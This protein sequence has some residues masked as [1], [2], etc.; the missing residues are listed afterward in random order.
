MQPQLAESNLSI[1]E[2]SGPG[3][4]TLNEYNSLFLRNRFALQASG[5]A[6]SNDIL[7]DELVQSTVWNKFSYSLG[8]YYYR[9]DG[10]REN[11]DQQRRLYNGY[12]QGMISP[13]T[14]WM[15]ELRY[16]K[17][18][19]GDLQI[20]FDPTEYYPNSRQSEERKSARIGLR[21][22]LKPN[23][24]I[25]GT[26][27]IG[28]NE[29]VGTGFDEGDFSVDI[30]GE[31]DSVMGEV[32]HI[33]NCG[34]FR[35]QSGAGYIY[36]DTND[37][38]TITFP[39]DSA[40]EEDFT[41]RH[42][43]LYSYAQVDLPHQ[44]TATLGLS[45]D[46]LDS[47]VK[48]REQLNPKIG[49]TWQP[50]NSTLIRGAVFSTVQRDLLYAQTVEPTHVSGFNQFFDDFDSTSAWTYG[51]GI[52]QNFSKKWFGGAQFYHRDLN[53]PFTEITNPE[54]PPMQSEDD[55]QEDIASVYL[56]WAPVSWTSI[57]LEY[58]YEK[59]T[60]DET[61]GQQEASDLTSH[62]LTPQV[63]FFLPA[64]FSARL[65]AH[66]IDQSGEFEI[67]PFGDTA[68]DGDQFW[69]VDLAIRYRLPKRYGILSL[70]VKKPV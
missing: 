20:L 70:G 58:Y 27:I 68:E 21:H 59:F 23:S 69:V 2:G 41:S 67:S 48:D 43:N 29:G 14:S 5:V 16:K 44:V 52:N 62:R 12:V 33:Y 60:Q 65:Q 17:D 4:A 54:L 53:V 28:N 30:S 63:S 26:A 36:S 13:K 51:I 24:T 9:S 35:L 66:Y 10:I 47:E 42:A 22:D 8:Q 38:V 61:Q 15:A 11:N 39:F 1:L 55:W 49:L 7:G 50:T 18:D 3:Q 46:L 64:G 56:Y 34:R 45:G 32:L 57:G 31:T 6:G 19:F 40:N 37:T 25:L